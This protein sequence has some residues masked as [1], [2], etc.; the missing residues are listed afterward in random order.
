MMELFVEISEELSPAGNPALPRRSSHTIYILLLLLSVK[1]A[2]ID[3]V[4][5]QSQLVPRLGRD[6]GYEQAKAKLRCVESDE[7]AVA[8]GPPA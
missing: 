2:G 4:Q 7:V 8:F 1:A 6:S 3:N 5:L